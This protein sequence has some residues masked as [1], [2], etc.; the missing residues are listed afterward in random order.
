MDAA[1][2]MT[3]GKHARMKRHLGISWSAS[4]KLGESPNW[5]FCTSTFSK[6]WGNG[7]G[8]LMGRPE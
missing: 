2:C 3:C 6:I 8:R 4:V 1:H 7:N 5:M